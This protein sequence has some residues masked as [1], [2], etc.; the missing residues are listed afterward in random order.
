MA[1]DEALETLMAT[2]AAGLPAL[3]VGQLVWLLGV[4]TAGACVQ[5]LGLHQLQ[6]DRSY[7]MV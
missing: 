3:G 6:I 2:I 7:F 4:E 1:V 5:A